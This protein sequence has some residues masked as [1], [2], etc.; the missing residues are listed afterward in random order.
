MN[1]GAEFSYAVSLRRLLPQA[2]FVGCTNL[3]VTDAVE[4][5]TD[6]RPG[7]LFAVI[8]G[9]RVDARQF[10]QDAISRNPAGLLV[11][12]AIPNLAIPQCIVKDV[13]SSY[14]RVCESLAGEPSRRLKTAGITGTNGKTTTSWLIRS[15]LEQSGHR[16]GV[17]G[18]VEYSDGQRTESATLTTP[19]SRTLAQWLGQMVRTGTDYASIELSS[20][21]LHQGRAAGI[22]LEAAVITNITQ[23]HFDYHQTF[24]AY[25]KA[26]AKICDMVRPGGLIALNLD[27][28]GAQTIHRRQGQS[29]LCQTFGLTPAADI[30]AQIRD[31]SLTGTRFRLQL[32]GK[33]WD[34]ATRLIGRHNLSNILGAVAVCTH[35]GLTPQEIVAGIEEFRCVPGRLERVDCGQPFEAFVDYAHTDDALQRC[36]SGL[37]ALTPGRVICIFGAGGDRDRT[38]RPK[39]GRAALTA[40]IA[41]VTSDN[42]RSENPNRIID[43]ILAGMGESTQKIVVEPDRRSAIKLALEIA[44]P[45]DCVLIAGKGHECEQIIGGDR[46]PFDDRQITRE[47]LRERWQPLAQPQLRV[48]A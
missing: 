42:P 45:G 9:T 15:L 36:L 27:D 41:I 6:A 39:L 5:S 20:H 4:R 44:S 38:K 25:L 17:L 19:D 22:E 16:C 46:I 18:T 7:S 28:P 29:H 3:C 23:D 8:R 35:F 13:R 26:K 14:S 31:Q 30:S 43:E 34:C 1:Q 24:D 10:L 47:I 33:T 32:N 2:N 40:D 11:D 12:E 37:R 48:S 21:A